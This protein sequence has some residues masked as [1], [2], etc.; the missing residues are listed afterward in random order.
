MSELAVLQA[1]RLKGRVSTADLTATLGEDESSVAVTVEQLT[2][3]GL[4]IGGA[5]LRIT[6][7]G[8]ARLGELLA[9]ERNGIDAAAFAVVYDDF[10]S[11]NGE[12]KALI[13]DWQVRDGEA[14]THED[15][16]YDAGVLARLDSVHQR[17]L[18]IVAAAA[19]QL[20]RL[21]RYAA[22]LQAA[23]ERIKA[24]ET[25]WLSRPLIDSY[26]TVWFELHEELILAAGR[27]RDVEAKAGG[28]G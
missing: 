22:K 7:E 16:D 2:A 4:L 17:V 12:F 27:S 19:G 6:P 14:N 3:S 10:R 23:F 20:P 13:T 28:A 21:N 9:D 15:T 24:G 11:V 25:M 5:T 26:H 1:V 18:P 8:R